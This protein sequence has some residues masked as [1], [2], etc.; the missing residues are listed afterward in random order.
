[1]NAEIIEKLFSDPNV[2]TIPILDVLTVIITYLRIS[3]EIN[4]ERTDKTTRPE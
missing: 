3:E 4:Y 2:R 1:M